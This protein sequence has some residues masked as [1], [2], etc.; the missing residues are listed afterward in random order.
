[1][2]ESLL[3]PWVCERYRTD[4]KYREGHRRILAPKPG[5]VVLGLHTPEMKKV[6]KQLARR[7]DWRN[8]LDG[9]A[10]AEKEMA[11]VSEA[12]PGKKAPEKTEVSARDEVEKE[13]A[14]TVA[15][16]NAAVSEAALGKKAPE[17]TEVSARDEV[18]K[19]EA[20][21]VAG[22]NAAVSEAAPGKKAPEKESW[23][24]PRHLSH[25]ERMVW[26]L[27]L[28]AVQ[29]PLEERLRR[30][31]AFIPAID[32]WA[33]CDNFC[34]NAKWLTKLTRKASGRSN[35]T[36]SKSLSAGSSHFSRT[37]SGLL[38]ETAGPVRLSMISGSLPGSESMTG[39]KETVW[40]WMEGHFKAE[41]EFERRV[42]VVLAMC[43]FL[44]PEDFDRTLDRIGSL[45]LREGEPY[46]VRMAVAWL[47]A[48]A[49]AKNPDRTR[50]FVNK[51]VPRAQTAHAA[52][53]PVPTGHVG[54]PTARAGAADA[55][56]AP[57]LPDD[58]IRLYIRKARESRITHNLS[59]L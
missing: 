44:E 11:A 5:T 55:R 42:P 24:T 14:M 30:I 6:A 39:E 9:F 43:H 19:E 40:R 50:A 37:E 4:P 21:T 17:K 26:G 35:A 12:A 1:M 16:G 38:P 58:I 54:A 2:I 31:D 32:N 47:L 7:P 51:A 36:K 57:S 56:P 49:L 18:E 10:A 29:C 48:T 53:A 27:M 20:M 59:A 3:T 28:D 46:Y 13:E 41:D 8:I 52:S 15:G 22:G 23:G 25:D 33:I 34:C 45:G